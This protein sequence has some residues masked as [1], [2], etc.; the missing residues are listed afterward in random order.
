MDRIRWVFAL[1]ALLLLVPMGLLVNRAFESAA[2]E[3]EVNHRVVAE[4]LL[5]GGDV[6]EVDGI[7]PEPFGQHRVELV[8]VVVLALVAEEQHTNRAFLRLGLG[9]NFGHRKNRQHGRDNGD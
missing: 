9:F 3:R 6:V 5:D 1:L 4:R 2:F 8:A 7:P